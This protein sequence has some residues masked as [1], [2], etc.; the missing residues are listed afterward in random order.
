MT[1]NFGWIED[2]VFTIN[3]K[4]RQNALRRAGFSLIRADELMYFFDQI[5]GAATDPGVNFSQAIIGFDVESLASATAP[6]STIHSALFS[7][8]RN[9]RRATASIKGTDA[10]DSSGSGQ[11]FEQAIADG[12]LEKVVD[13]I[14]NAVTV[15]LAKLISVD[16][17]T[18]DAL[19]GSILA[20]GLDSLVAVELRNWIMRQ[21]DAPLQ[22]SEILANQTVQALAEKIAARSKKVVLVAA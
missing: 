4:T 16:A 8:V 18:I 12:N 10:D 14:S 3:D 2:A 17:E 21:F 11:T 15:Q 7:Q 19:Q 6:N 22:S 9:A 13:F 1:I 20:L 5:L